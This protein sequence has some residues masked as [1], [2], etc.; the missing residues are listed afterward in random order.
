MLTDEHVIQMLY[1]HRLRKGI[2][3]P[4]CGSTK[5]IEYGKALNR[6]YIQRYLCRFCE[7]Q[8]NDTTD[9]SFA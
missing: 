2:T 6:P 9:T 4:Y 7:R 8:F 1:K 3:C 5:V